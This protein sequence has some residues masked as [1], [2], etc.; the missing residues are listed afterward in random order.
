M[1]Y[2]MYWQLELC[3]VQYAMYWQLELSC[4]LH[5]YLCRRCSV[6]HVLAVGAVP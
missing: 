6:C 4:K 5:M 2:A 1:Q 3:T